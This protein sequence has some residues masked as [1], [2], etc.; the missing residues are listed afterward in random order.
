VVAVR[1]V[2]VEECSTGETSDAEIIRCVLCGDV[3]AFEK[4]MGRY[5]SRV[6]SIVMKHVPA[7]SVEDVAQETFLEAYRSLRSFSEKS[8]FSHWLSRI[9]TRCCYHF[10]RE[11]S[12]NPTV[13]VSSLSDDAEQWMDRVLAAS[14]HEAFEQ[15]AERQEAAEV[16]AY[17]L[18][19]LSI[20]DRMVLTLVHLDGYPVKEAATLLGWNIVSVKVRAHRSRRKLRKIVSDLLNEK[21]GGV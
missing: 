16:L 13:P 11:R 1:T 17:A 9:A 19:E 20:E 18:G 8:P 7:E 21:R 4:L 15:E 2:S 12:G 3:N 14:S 10:W 6:F 5:Q